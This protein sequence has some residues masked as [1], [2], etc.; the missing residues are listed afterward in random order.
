MFKFWFILE[1]SSKLSLTM[2]FFI[3]HFENIIYFL[4]IDFID[5]KIILLAYIK[6]NKSKKYSF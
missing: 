5:K 1:I 2:K 3:N 6:L 4:Q